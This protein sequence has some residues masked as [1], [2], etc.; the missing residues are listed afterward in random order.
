[1]QR[2]VINSQLSNFFTYEMY[3]RQCLSLAE[4]VVQL[5]NVPDFIDLSRVNSWL[6][7]RGVVAWFIDEIENTLVCLPYTSISKRDIYNRPLEIVV[8]AP[9]GYTRRLSENDFVLMFDNS[10][11]VPIYMDI[12]QYA[13]RLALDTRIIDINISQQKTPRLWQTSREQEQSVRKLVN[14]ID[15][16]VDK[17]VSYE[18]LSVDEINCV[19]NAAPYIADKVEQSKE[20][21]WNEFLRFIGVTNIT[22]QKKERLLKDEV[23]TMQGGT[24]ASRFSRLIPKQKAVY[25]INKKLVPFVK[26]QAPIELIYYDE[27]YKGVENFD[28]S[29]VYSE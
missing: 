24:F 11:K 13:E 26:G 6:V 17:V 29:N 23:E 28:F 18:N 2:K 19:L 21:T 14:D 25:E 10:L 7:R 12:C 27:F 4:N 22:Q 1:M 16:L 15:G 5:K 20:K 3:K 8:Q 9:N